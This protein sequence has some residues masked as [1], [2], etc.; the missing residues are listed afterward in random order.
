MNAARFDPI[1]ARYPSL[2]V[3][4]LGDFC[5]DRYLEI[6]PAR[7]ETSIETGL[8]VHNVTS[9][10]SQPGAAGTILNNL[11]ALGV[12]AIHPIGFCGEDGEGFELLRALGAQPGVRL[13]HFLPT[14]LRRTFTYCKPLVLAAGQ[15]PRE[16]NRLD[17]KNW[18]PTPVEVEDRLRDSA[19]E[20]A[21]AVDAIIVMD[22]VDLADTGV[23]TRRVLET[24]AEVAR[25][26][27]AKLVIADSRRGLRDFPPVTFKMNSAELAALT[28]AGT[29]TEMEEIRRHACELAARNRRSVFVTLAERGIVG[30]G[31]DGVVEQ[32]PALPVRGEIDIVGAGDAETLALARAA[33][34]IVIHQLGTTGTASVAQIRELLGRAAEASSV[35]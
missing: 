26:N 7:A 28:G 19:R 10:R 15:P 29:L 23:V 6:D 1:T 16:L 12:G 35:D 20:L 3:A 13:D 4:I 9:V 21:A 22:Q 5:L 18:T 2:R 11:V 8:A 25:N 14:P 34:N 31:A 33:A 30:A 24:V 17:S 32:V 27:P